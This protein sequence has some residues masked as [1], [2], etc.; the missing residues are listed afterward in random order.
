M[1]LKV[2]IIGAGQA[3]EHHAVG[4]S[5]VSGVR[6]TGI[7]DLAMKRATRVAER[8]DAQPYED[9]RHMLDGGLDILVVALPHNLHVEPAEVAAARGMHLL[10]EKPIATTMDDARR[11]VDVCREARVKLTISFVHRFRDELQIARRWIQENQLGE[12]RAAI[13]IMNGQRGPHSPPWIT[14]K[15]IAGGGVLMYGAIHSVDRLRWLLMSDV[16][17]VAAQKQHFEPRTEVEDGVTALLTFTNGATATLSACA[18]AYRAQPAY[19]DSQIY[20]TQGMI[21]IRT[22]HWAELSNDHISVRQESRS[23]VA[24][25]E[26][27]NFAR[28]AQA[29]VNA[30]LADDE[31]AISGDDGLRAL[32]VAM[33]IYHAA[34]TGEIVRL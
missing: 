7:A 1:T 6:I 22:R 24:M 14:N 5:T 4:F 21:R 32:E 28:Q 34:S 31:P 27:Y 10:M 12:P 19:W 33:A 15:E 8:F 29:F 30:I 2:G 26:H 9:W 3:G 16:T 25:G 20:G 23:A 18:P 17:A 11:I 13:E